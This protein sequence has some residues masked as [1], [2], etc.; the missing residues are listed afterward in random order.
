MEFVLNENNEF[1]IYKYAVLT[2]IWIDKKDI[3]RLLSDQQG[4]EK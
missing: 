1:I 3:M 2:Y 4:I